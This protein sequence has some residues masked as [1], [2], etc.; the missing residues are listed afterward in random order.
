MSP[1]VTVVVPTYNSAR[2]VVP[3]L[4]SVLGQTYPLED[5]ELIVIDDA[6]P[7]DSVAVVEAFLAG[8]PIAHRV[9]ARTKNVG[10]G[11]SRNIAWREAKGEWIQALDADDLLAPHKLRCQMD[12]AMSGPPDLAVVY[13]NWQALTL[14]GE[15]WAPSGPI[16]AP[17]VDDDPVVRILEEHLFGY[18]GPALVRRSY[19]ER[20]GGFMERPNIGEDLDLMLRIAMAGGRFRQ[21]PSRAAAFLYRHTP[22]SLWRVSAKK[23]VPMRNLLETIRSA[24]EFLR[25]RSANGVLSVRERRALGRRYLRSVDHYLENDARSFEDLL[26][27]LG[28]LGIAYPPDSDVGMRVLSRTVGLER[29]LRARSALRRL[30][31]RFQRWRAI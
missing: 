31:E 25:A 28:D 20:I 12:V 1:K 4:E 17:F 22:G 2:W 3:T 27:W 16:H 5:V 21:A 26:R 14:Q 9:M 10:V 23:V 6:S 11:A 15:E 19:L 29:A 30:K 7:D 8:K 18:V 13:S 24:D